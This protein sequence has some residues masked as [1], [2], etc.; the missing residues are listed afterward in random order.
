MITILSVMAALMIN[1][2][3]EKLVDEERK[4]SPH[5]SL[6]IVRVLVLQG[7]AVSDASLAHI[8]PSQLGVASGLDIPTMVLVK[9][10]QLVVH[11]P[12]L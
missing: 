9:V 2:T 8:V 10:V 1:M 11:V 3:K 7:I 4:K 6:G 5:T 12:G